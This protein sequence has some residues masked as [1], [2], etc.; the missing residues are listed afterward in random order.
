MPLSSLNLITK[1]YRNVED[2]E[3]NDRLLDWI[4]FGKT[5]GK[6]IVVNIIGQCQKLDIAEKLKFYH[7]CICVDEST[8]IETTKTLVI[9]IYIKI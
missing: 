1:T 4:D 3:K 8:D 9:D 5:K 2:G 7:F 6:C